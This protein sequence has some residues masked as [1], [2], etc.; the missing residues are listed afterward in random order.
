MNEQSLVLDESIW[1][2]AVSTGGAI[3][4]SLITLALR[5]QNLITFYIL[6]V[7]LREYR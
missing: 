2:A 6:K 4:G 1:I 7:L 5:S 3:S